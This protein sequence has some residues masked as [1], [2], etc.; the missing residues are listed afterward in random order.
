M[1]RINLK[2]A[3]G[4]LF[5]G[6]M[7]GTAITLLYAPQSGAR[8]TRDIKKFA[9]RTVN[10]LDDVQQDIRDQVAHLV[11]EVTE[12]VKDSVDRGQRLGAEGYE[13]VLQGFDHA[14]RCVEDGKSRLEHLIKTT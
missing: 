8:T 12:I 4:F 3:A 9:R 7:V 14:K 11:D 2:Q 10:R 13:Q 6:A 5:A 1:T